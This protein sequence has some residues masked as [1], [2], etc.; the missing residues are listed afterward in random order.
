MTTVR[1]SS[2][3][4][5]LLAC[6]AVSCGIAYLCWLSAT[7]DERREAEIQAAIRA[8]EDGLTEYRRMGTVTPKEKP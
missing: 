7:E 5:P 6:I 1:P 4:W 2:S 8:A 3:A